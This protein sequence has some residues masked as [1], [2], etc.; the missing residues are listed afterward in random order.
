M[1]KLWETWA[2]VLQ[3]S[4]SFFTLLSQDVIYSIIVYPDLLYK[5]D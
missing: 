4:Q 5:I 1:G 2:S 3:V